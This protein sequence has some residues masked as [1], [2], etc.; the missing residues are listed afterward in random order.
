MYSKLLV[1]GELSE[2]EIQRQIIEWCNHIPEL[3]NMVIHIPNEGKRTISMGRK[4][5]QIGLRP[6]VADLFIPIPRHGYNGV[7]VEIKS[8]H[9]VLRENQREFLSDMEK[10]GYLTFISRSLEDFMQKINAYMKQ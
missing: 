6:G 1:N 5:R 9:G 10:Q 4:L 3:R 7:W 2:T 8:K